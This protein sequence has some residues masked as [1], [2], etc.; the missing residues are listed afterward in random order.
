[1][2]DEL[3]RAGSDCEFVC[4]PHSGN[5]I[6]LIKSQNFVVHVLSSGVLPTWLGVEWQKDASQTLKVV[7]NNTYDWLIID[8]YELDTKWESLLRPIANSIL[9]IDDLA[10][11]SHNADVILDQNSGRISLDYKNLAPKY[12]EIYTGPMFAFLRPEFYSLRVLSEQRKNRTEVLHLLISMGGVDKNNATTKVLE[13]LQ[14]MPNAL[15]NGSKITVLMGPHAPGIT[16]VQQQALKMPWPTEIL[17]GAKNVA[18]LMADADLMIGGVGTTIWEACC[19]G[20]PTLALILAENQLAAASHLERLGAIKLLSLDQSLDEWLSKSLRELQD[21]SNLRAMQEACYRLTDGRGASRFLNQLGGIGNR[22]KSS[23]REMTHDDLLM[24]LEWRNS[25]K[26]KSYMNTQHKISFEE[27]CIWFDR[28]IKDNSRAV[29]IY[30]SLNQPMGFVQFSNLE[31]KEG[32]I[33]G[34]YM[35]PNASKGSG[36]EMGKAALKYAF[37][38]LGTTKIFGRVMIDN[39]ASINFHKK[40]GFESTAKSAGAQ[41]LL[42]FR[43]T[44]SE[45]IKGLE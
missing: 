26:V 19:L 15:L 40:L 2:A 38:R 36:S 27:H 9:V 7:G 43:I 6:E 21:P 8:H 24:V 11:R 3:R 41:E 33:W 12:C 17:I 34:F 10:N 28:V 35:A 39:Y 4:R 5:L 29:L 16:K 20:L 30:E 31:S 32:A 22:K 1:M 44:Y 18:H 25:S 37:T 42:S 13:S 45:W 23:I 14:K